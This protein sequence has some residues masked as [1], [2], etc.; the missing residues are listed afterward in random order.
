MF[1][2]LLRRIS[3]YGSQ[4]FRIEARA[5]HDALDRDNDC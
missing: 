4:L 3:T 1:L 2:V 5:D